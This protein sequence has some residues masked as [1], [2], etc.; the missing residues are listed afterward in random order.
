[1]KLLIIAL[2]VVGW[3]V[4]QLALSRLFLRLPD[5]LFDADSWVTRVRPFESNG[6]LYRQYFFVQRWKGLLPDGASWLGG[7][8]KNNVASRR[9]ADLTVFAIET[10]RGELAHW[11]MLL[12]TP[13]FYVWNPLWAC[14][15]MTLYGIAA[16][17]PCI[18]VQ[19][20]NRI[21]VNRLLVRSNQ[22]QH[23]KVVVVSV[24]GD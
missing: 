3:P 7:R 15:V 13:V 1:M 23:R 24:A 20:A 4:I 6:E 2:N 10:R 22:D 5:H 8:S 19:R 14:C 12:C 9:F 17:L 21:K 11:C 16:N 18:L